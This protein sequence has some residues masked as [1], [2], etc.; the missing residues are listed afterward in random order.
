MKRVLIIVSS[1]FLLLV[2]AIVSG[3]TLMGNMRTVAVINA[4]GLDN[5]GVYLIMSG[6]PNFQFADMPQVLQPDRTALIDAV[7]PFGVLVKN[8]TAN[9]VVGCSL[10]WE[11]MS[12]DGTVKSLEQSFSTPGVLVGMEPLDE[13]MV[14]HTSLINANS[15]RFLSLDPRVKTMFESRES[16]SQV[17]AAVSERERQYVD[18]L[19]SKYD[20]QL[21][22][23]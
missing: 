2:I 11:L 6:E 1:A 10:K 9:D 16:E 18:K 4:K 5:D 22:S 15:T 17:S 7:G 8:A 23:V 3:F 14:G 12:S 20:K 19:K 21:G 13:S